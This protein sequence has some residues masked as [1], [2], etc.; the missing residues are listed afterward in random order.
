MNKLLLFILIC[1]FSFTCFSQNYFENYAYVGG[2]DLHPCKLLPSKD[3]GY[4]VLAYTGIHSEYQLKYSFLIKLDSLGN[5]LWNKEVDDGDQG[6]GYTLGDFSVA[7][8]SFVYVATNFIACLGDGDVVK[9]D[10]FGNYIWDMQTDLHIDIPNSKFYTICS[11]NNNDQLI[12]GA[13]AWNC[14]VSYP[15]LCRI[16]PNGNIIWDHTWDTLYPGQSISRI[17]LFHDTTFLVHL[18]SATVQINDSGQIIS[19]NFPAGSFIPLPNGEFIVGSAHQITRL[20]DSLTI[21]WQSPLYQDRELKDIK[22]NPSGEFFV[23]GRL[24]TLNSEMFVSKLDTSGNIL[25]TKIY[26]GDLFDEGECIFIPDSNHVVAAGMHQVHQWSV[27][28]HHF[29]DCILYITYTTAVSLV[30][31]NQ[32]ALTTQQCQSSSNS[33]ILCNND[34]LILNAPSGYSYSWNTGETSQSIVIDTSGFYQVTI[35]DTSGN[36][37]ILPAF[38]SYKYPFPSLP[39]TPDLFI[40]ACNG[41]NA[42]A[43][44]SMPYSNSI[45]DRNYG[46]FLNGSGD[47]TSGPNLF[48]IPGLPPG[49]YYGISS[50]ACG[51]DTTGRTIIIA[52]SPSVNLGNDTTVICSVQPIILNA[53]NGYS[54]YYWQDGS[55]D[56]VYIVSLSGSYSVNVEDSLYCPA[57]DNIVVTMIPPATIYLGNDTT[58]CITQS[59]TIEAG[60]GFNSYQWQDS[61]TSEFFTA[62]S[63]IADT[64]QLY[65]TITDTNSCSSSDTILI[66]FDICS[67]INTWTENNFIVLP[68]LFSDYISLDFSGNRTE[69]AMLKI[70]DTVGKAYFS[71]CILQT[72]QQLDLSFLAKGIYILTLQTQEKIFSLKI[73]KM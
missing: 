64:L 24:D 51:M 48:D 32:N 67:G 42:D 6:I 49:I 70:F 13:I 14:N 1:P 54:S 58:I 22:I 27:T 35:T 16:S 31:L 15:Y 18:T 73:V 53:V 60:S 30:K 43:C 28:G 19:T 39:H 59:I 44:L 61:T 41:N 9:Y 8:D 20:T 33:Y 65:V 47:L 7:P 11:A 23:T 55:T 10:R 71:K 5:E 69:K 36:Q 3:N 2:A 45:Y 50:N 4:Y 34:S 12:G 56:S 17:E 29:Y 62:S 72:N 52:D 38:N 37:E 25:F 66:I 68:N 40:G 63:P 57:S 26:G 21:A 46:W